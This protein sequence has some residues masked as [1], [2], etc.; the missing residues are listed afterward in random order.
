[1]TDCLFCKIID[2]K[3]PSSKVYEDDQVFAFKDIKPHAPIHYLFI[4]KKHF[5]SLADLPEGD[6]I[7]MTHLFSALKKVADKEGI[8]ADGY[9]TVI[10]TRKHGCQTVDHLHIHLLGG[11]QLGGNM[12]GN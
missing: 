3:I 2:G 6:A 7:V 12:A 11:R 5:K 8:S 1:M 10:N 9:R 4:P